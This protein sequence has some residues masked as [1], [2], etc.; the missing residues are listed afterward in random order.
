VT[1]LSDDPLCAAVLARPDDD[2]SLRWFEKELFAQ[3]G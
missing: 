3:L 1:D 2:S